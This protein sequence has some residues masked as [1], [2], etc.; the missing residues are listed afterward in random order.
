MK[1]A[2]EKA[3]ELY[4]LVSE[5]RARQWKKEERKKRIDEISYYEKRTRKDPKDSFAW[6][7]LALKYEQDTW[8]S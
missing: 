4:D 1:L 2:F 5:E 6:S 8:L 3:L 7:S